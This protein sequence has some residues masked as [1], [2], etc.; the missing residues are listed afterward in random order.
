[1]DHAELDTALAAGEFSLG[2]R[3]EDPIASHI[4]AIM[5]HLGEDTKRPG[6]RQTPRRFAEAMRFLAGGY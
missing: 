1:M 5:A 2:Y 3:P 4:E 6:L